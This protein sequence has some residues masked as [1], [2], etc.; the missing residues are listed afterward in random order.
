[1]FPVSDAPE[2]K[3]IHINTQTILNK[4]NLSVSFKT[5]IKWKSVLSYETSYKNAMILRD[6]FVIYMK[7]K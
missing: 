1:M 6:I 5:D 7:L 3:N 4:I 2:M